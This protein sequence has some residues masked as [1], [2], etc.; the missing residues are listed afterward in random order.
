MRI[1]RC[2]FDAHGKAIL[3]IL[4]DAI[5]NTTAIYDYQ[6]RPLSAME[7]W[8]EAKELQGFP[9]VGVESDGGDL[10]GFASFG[11]FRAWP[12]YKY[13]VEHSVYVHPG[14]RGHGLG[15]ML[16]R[17][18]IARARADERHVIVGGI[19]AENLASIRL[20]EKLGFAHVGTIRH[21][22]FKFG[23]WLDLALYQLILETP[24]APVDG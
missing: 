6:P 19:D 4:N 12:A 22:G 13:T 16:T 8:F 18:I 10:L 3:E 11:P 7:T 2:R 15:A 23:R 17:E 5:V 24:T 21:A 14:H 9:V 1:V 20:H